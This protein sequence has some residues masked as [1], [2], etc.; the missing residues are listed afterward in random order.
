MD[1][2]TD[3]ELR[4]FCKWYKNRFGKTTDEEVL[5]TC[6]CGHFHSFPKAMKEQLRRMQ[7]LGLITVNKDKTITI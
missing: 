6:M 2:I 3:T 5:V 7:S 1:R 4:D